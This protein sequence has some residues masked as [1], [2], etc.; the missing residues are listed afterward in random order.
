MEV[1]T[2]LVSSRATAGRIINWMS[3]AYSQRH[4][5]ISYKAPTK[6]SFLEIGD[7]ISVSDDELSWDEQILMV[8]SVE[9]G[10]TELTFTFLLIP[11]I[12][13]DMIPLG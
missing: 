7:I 12:P 5:Q 1:E 3:R 11:D 9:W 4:R 8:Q 6:L 13:R 2:E 10:E